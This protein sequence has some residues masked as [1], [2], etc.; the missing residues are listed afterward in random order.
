MCLGRRPACGLGRPPP[1]PHRHR[2]GEGLRRVL[3]PPRPP[4]DPRI[5]QRG[6]RGAAAAAR[7][8]GRRGIARC[9]E[10]RPV[11]PRTDRRQ[12]TRCAVVHAF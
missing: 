9:S 4:R 11:P 5:A 12:R 8:G 10:E 2:L 7:S 1:G 6:R 3:A